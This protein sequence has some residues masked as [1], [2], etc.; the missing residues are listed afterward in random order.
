[1]CE[2]TTKFIDKSLTDFVSDD[3]FENALEA[4]DTKKL[5]NILSKIIREPYTWGK[6]IYE[7]LFEKYFSEQAAHY[8]DISKNTYHELIEK[9]FAENGLENRGSLSSS[10]RLNQLLPLFEKPSVEIKRD[11]VYLFAY[12]LGMNVKELS[13]LMRKAL[14]QPVVNL[15]D[16]KEV[17]YFWCFDHDC[18]NKIDKIHEL[19]DFY[20]E[21]PAEQDL[22]SKEVKDKTTQT[23]L[24]VFI[25]HIQNESQLKEYLRTLK[26]SNPK[27]N[28]RSLRD[29][30]RL[31][32]QRMP[33]IPLEKELQP[34]IAETDL[35]ALE[36]DDAK[37]S[38]L[39]SCQEIIKQLDAQR[40]LYYEENTCQLLNPDT[41]KLLFK[42]INWSAKSLQKRFDGSQTISRN[43][44]LLSIFFIHCAPLSE[45]KFRVSDPEDL[46][47]ER[48][49]HYRE[50]ID[51]TLKDSCMLLTYPRNPFELFLFVCM[52]H[53]K[54]YEYLMA[55]WYQAIS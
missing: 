22:T 44:F 25:E 9:L 10:T 48:Y 32:F 37:Y 47:L 6:Y 8:E 52:F 13:K 41:I 11:V 15:R 46:K 31:N 28:S 30:F 5:E 1:M 50:C 49:Y 51:K 55:N 53:D 36:K 23:L 24:E 26:N 19:L 42:G 39:L 40:K 21:L 2:L 34:D 33:K 7:Y 43:E 18:G 38:S 4:G 45:P 29:E 35:I 54:P 16:Y 27:K 3:D 12:G 20:T 14:L 17:V